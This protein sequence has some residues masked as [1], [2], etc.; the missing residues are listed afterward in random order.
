MSKPRRYPHGQ[1]DA[2]AAALLARNPKLTRAEI[3]K[4]LGCNARSL[5]NRAK[6]PIL[7]RMWAQIKSAKWDRHP[8]DTRP[9]RRHNGRSMPNLDDD[10][11]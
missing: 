5:M 3:A 2:V 1:L 10:D 6:Y 9:D 8:G 4:K 7:A 11:D